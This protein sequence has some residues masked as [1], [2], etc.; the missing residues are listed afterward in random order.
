MN[1]AS[2]ASPLYRQASEALAQDI[3][4]GLLPAGEAL[5]QLGIARRFGI[6]R[7]P[8]RRALEELARAGMLRR[9]PSGRFEV[10]GA[11]ASAAPRP[12]APTVLTQQPAWER[13]YP[14]IELAIISHASLASWRVNE[15][16]L[17][18][19][20]GVSRTVARD[21]MGRLQQRGIVRKDDSGRWLAPALTA[22]HMNELY[23]LRWLLEPVAM[24]K[25]VP[26][27]PP[28][29]LDVMEDELRQAIKRG[30]ALDGAVLDRLEQRLHVELLG[31]CGNGA[32]M[33]A[34]G[35]PQALL[36]AHHF[37][38][39]LTL[40]LFGTEPFLG[41]HLEIVRLLKAGDIAG[42]K[43]ALVAHLRISRRRALLRIEAVQDMIQPD[44]L[45][46]LDRV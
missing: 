2:L 32:L 18:R 23:E 5:T 39:A 7:A 35:L 43:A 6:S 4:Q 22:D 1:Q 28:G 36:V 10:V 14:E 26:H 46:W 17:A 27:L 29:F 30:A 13:L 45:P 40:E 42:A 24:E 37:L 19:H 11:P 3:A 25:A 41:E 34:I 9:A 20:H 38:Y 31:H 44:P 15:A 12:A 33:Q 8:A 21:V 16:M